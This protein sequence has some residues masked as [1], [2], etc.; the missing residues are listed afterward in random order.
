M[1]QY[2][3]ITHLGKI[4]AV[5]WQKILYIFMDFYKK[6]IFKLNMINFNT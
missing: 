4:V 5:F 3:T 1:N 6:F 2:S